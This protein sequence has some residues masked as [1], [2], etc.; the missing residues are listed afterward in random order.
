MIAQTQNAENALAS[1][2]VELAKAVEQ[3]TIQTEL[4]RQQM[5]AMDQ[6]SHDHAARASALDVEVARL[7]GEKAALVAQTEAAEA[8]LAAISVEL[9]QAVEQS[10][11]QTESFRQQMIALDQASHDHAARAGALQIEIAELHRE[12]ADKVLALDA[13]MASLREAHDAELAELRSEMQMLREDAKNALAGA[14]LARAE[15]A[16]ACRQR[17]VARVAARR[18]AIVSQEWQ[19]RYYALRGRLDTALKRSWI[20]PASRLIPPT[21]RRRLRETLLGGPHR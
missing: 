19:G 9:S 14:D 18:A 20:L 8:A 10:T 4:F 13:E 7:N 3:S 12:H 5:T 17:D 21:L 6:A 11:M 15:A 16:H 2:A 1:M